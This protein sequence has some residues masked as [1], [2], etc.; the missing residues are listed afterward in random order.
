MARRGAAPPGGTPLRTRTLCAYTKWMS[1][2]FS[3]FVS[4][5]LSI[6]TCRSIICRIVFRFGSAT[7]GNQAH[8]KRTSLVPWYN[9]YREISLLDCDR[10]STISITIEGY[11]LL[12][13]WF[14]RVKSIS[15]FFFEEDAALH[16]F[17]CTGSKKHRQS[18]NAGALHM[19]R[20][21]CTDKRSI[22]QLLTFA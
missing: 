17:H 6:F 18:L 13:P 3:L 21:V 2:F 16:V 15:F 5:F 20:R 22:A 12:V 14:S 7:I 10:W 8:V 9:F 11:F 19:Q 4:I 1:L